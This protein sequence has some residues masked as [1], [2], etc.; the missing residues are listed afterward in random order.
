M[1]E[2]IIGDSH[3]FDPSEH[4]AV[5]TFSGTSCAQHDVKQQDV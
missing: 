1:E 3:W 5:R 2:V 4:N